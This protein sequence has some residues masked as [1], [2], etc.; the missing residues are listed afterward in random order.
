[1][2]AVGVRL[3]CNGAD[4]G[5]VLI[6]RPGSI[7]EL[8]TKA[9]VKLPT[10]VAPDISVMRLFDEKGFEVDD[11]DALQLLPDRSIVYMYASF[12]GAAFIETNE[13]GGNSVDRDGRVNA[14]ALDRYD[15]S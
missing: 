2:S 1:M 6:V 7:I 11:D 10:D 9:A 14:D 4:S 12:D 8:K 15:A 3:R 13:S 5:G